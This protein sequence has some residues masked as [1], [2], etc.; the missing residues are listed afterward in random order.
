VRAVDV[1]EHHGE[2]IGAASPRFGRLA[3]LGLTAIVFLLYGQTISYGYNGLDDERMIRKDHAFLKDLSHVPQAFARDVFGNEEGKRNYYRP[4]LTLSLM[5]DTQLGGVDITAFRVTNVLLHALSTCLLLYFLMAI[6]VHRELALFLAIAFAVHPLHV[7]AVALVS[8]RNDPL[9]AVF[10]LSSLLQLIRFQRTG[11]GLA[12]GLHILCLALALFTKESALALLVVQPLLVG[13]ILQQD[14]RSGRNRAL[15]AAWL[16]VLAIWFWLRS[17]A[18]PSGTGATIGPVNF[19][20]NLPMLPQYVGK[21]FFPFNLSLFPTIPDTGFFYGVLALGIT[22]AALILSREV[23]W[24]RVVFGGA[25]F[26]AFLLPSLTVGGTP[27][28]EQRMYVP[29]VGFMVV[30]CETDLLGR[31]DPRSWRFASVASVVIVGFFA[32]S[33]LRCQAFRDFESF[34]QSAVEDSPHSR[35]AHLFYG[36]ELEKRGRLDEAESLYRGYLERE[37]SKHGIHHRLAVILG[38][39]RRFAQAERHFLAELE[40]NPGFADAQFG[41]GVLYEQTGR[42]SQAVELWR[43]I[44]ENDPRA[45]GAYRAL[46][47]HYRSRGDR[48]RA[49]EV[50]EEMRRQGIGDP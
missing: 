24:G 30:L 32:I 47:T 34:W 11:S 37:V 12:C 23:A 50:L 35:L 22:I 8:G 31:A 46:V 40:I 36:I 2:R 5:L 7:F 29:L 44:I 28:F 9:L 1:S 17:V 38:K 41:L 21:I 19:L 18:L 49:Q 43:Q 48:A 16:L 26:L 20:F 3:C 6:G 27:G 10:V 39:Q 42:A 15:G 4:L 45:I 14:L 25:W 33:F 13:L